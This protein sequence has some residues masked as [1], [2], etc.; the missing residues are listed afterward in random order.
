MP[1]KGQEYIYMN[2]I[3][4]EGSA[5]KI[6]LDKIVIFIKS[7]IKWTGMTGRALTDGNTLF[8]GTQ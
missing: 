8:K 7:I 3:S 4:Y 5:I 2:K 1:G 6:N